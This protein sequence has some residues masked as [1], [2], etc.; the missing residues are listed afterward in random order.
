MQIAERVWKPGVRGAVWQ[1]LAVVATV[2]S[3]CATMGGRRSRV[4]SEGA[5]QLSLWDDI[6]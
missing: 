1:G 3:P 2:I 4:E 5:V 6:E